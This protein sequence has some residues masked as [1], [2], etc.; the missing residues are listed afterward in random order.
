MQDWTLSNYLLA[1]GS[2]L[3]ALAMWATQVTP[4][5]AVSHAS[6]WTRTFGLREQPHWLKS[7]NADRV[8]R[9]VGALLLAGCLLFLLFGLLELG[10]ADVG[11]KL[12]FGIGC[13]G[14]IGTIILHLFFPDI[15]PQPIH[16]VILGAAI[17]LG[18][19]IG[20]L[21]M[22]GIEAAKSVDSGSAT[23]PENHTPLSLP[24]APPAP[25]R[26]TAYEKEQRLRAVDEIYKV[27]SAKL[28]PLYSEG[29]YIFNHLLP[30]I[31]DGS[32]EQ[33]L[34]EH[35]KKVDDAFNDMMGLI[36]Q[37]QYFPDIVQIPREKPVFNAIE[38][39][40]AARNL[41]GTIAF[42]KNNVQPGALSQALERDVTL[43][44]AR[45]ASRN[46]SQFLEATMPKLQAKRG[47]IEKAEVYSG[48]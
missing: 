46:F 11:L 48:K 1:I 25:L 2:I 38:E 33:K 41:V 24:A 44:E 12:L 35:A 45:N 14:V 28:S 26:Y 42:L 43:L 40:N 6:E 34:N 16:F 13:A 22:S 36:K 8:I 31:G 5:Q 37:Y 7:E 21:R 20:Q 3:G 29:Q 23:R 10:K 47:E 17:V 15:A 9:H 30:L 27:I 4:Q 32:A 19:A 18:A 39:S